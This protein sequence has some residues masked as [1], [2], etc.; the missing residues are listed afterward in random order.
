MTFFSSKPKLH[1]S[2]ED[3]VWI[4]DSLLWF[5]EEFGR[6]PLLAKTII[7]TKEFFP[8]PLINTLESVKD[9]VTI[10]C[11]YMKVN[12]KEIEVSLL[13]GID[14]LHKQI[15]HKDNTPGG[16]FQKKMKSNMYQIEINEKNTSNLIKT[17]ATISH[18]LCHVHLHG[19]NRI[20]REEPDHEHLTDLLKVF[21]GMGIFNANSTFSFQQH[22]NGWQHSSSGY[23]SEQMFGYALACYSWMRGD[24][25][26]TWIKYL[27][28]NVKTYCQDS[29]EYLI[30]TQDTA[31]K[32]V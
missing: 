9:M 26:P 22:E 7:P 2:L 8:L 18:E 25:N 1:I 14:P 16:T 10:I 13:S 6:E 28:L 21:F 17:I 32:K 4:E 27:D 12:P 30:E 31:L 3:K 15:S 24:F 23:L 20:T 5:L 11:S 29:L 19:Q